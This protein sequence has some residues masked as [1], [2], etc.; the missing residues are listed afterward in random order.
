MTNNH[1]LRRQLLLAGLG[2]SSLALA[3]CA[4]SQAIP[5]AATAAD[6]PLTS[7][8]P[9][10]LPGTHQMDVRWGN[11]VHRLFVTV[12]VGPAPA[13]GYPVLY[14][15]DGNTFFPIVS[16]LVRSQAWRNDGQRNEAVVVSLG[17]ATN[18]LYDAQR[19]RDYTPPA[20]GTEDGGKD[21]KQGGADNFLDFIEQKVQPMVAR[22]FKPDPQRQT[23]FGH[24]YGGLLTL[25]TLFTRPHMFQRYAAASPSI[26]WGD[27]FL[28]KERERF[29]AQMQSR[30][31]P[32][33]ALWIS[34]GGLEETPL[35]ADVNAPRATTLRDRRQ[36][37]SARDMVESLKGVPGLRTRFTIFD[38]M[39]HG[40]VRSPATAQAV[41]LALE[42]RA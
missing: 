42:D 14:A 16:Q 11:H 33:T 19:G 13:N 1:L 7:A 29:L 17:Y 5:T 20:P 35:P 30:I 37:S 2:G 8:P 27:R 24:S 10:S 12:P 28:L 38:G 23:L 39:D 32:G 9:V 21:R 4:S 41:A 40:T 34:V 6:L 3:G 25:H 36:V 15:L 31:K 22:E 26:W 18:E